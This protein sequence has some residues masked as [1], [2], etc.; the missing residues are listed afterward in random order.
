MNNT[1]RLAQTRALTRR[2]F[3]CQT[4][5]SL[6]AVALG[7][8]L[9]REGYAGVAPA[10]RTT[11]PLGPRKPHFAPKAKSIIYLD[12]SGAPPSLD[13]FDWKPKLAEL[14]LKPCPEELLKGQRFRSEERR[15]GKECRSR[16]AT[17]QSKKK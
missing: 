14:N 9:S 4:G 15:V 5:L 13:M 11:N 6:G 17:Y 16:W 2:Q 8:L 10:L 3:F 1:F 12:M 7:G